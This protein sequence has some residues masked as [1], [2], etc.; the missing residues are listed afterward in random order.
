MKTNP[1]ISFIIPIYNFE[2]WISKCIDSILKQTNENYEIIIAD[3]GSTDNTG[4][5]C[6][7]YSNDYPNIKY[8]YLKHQGLPKTRVDSLDY[9]SGDYIAFVD[10]DDWVDKNFV[11]E[12]F[13]ITSRYDDV[14]IIYFYEEFVYSNKSIVRKHS[15]PPYSGLYNNKNGLI[16]IKKSILSSF[17]KKYPKLAIHYGHCLIK[18]DLVKKWIYYSPNLL[19]GEDRISLVEI[20]FNSSSI[21]FSDKILYYYNCNNPDSMTAQQGMGPDLDYYMKLYEKHNNKDTDLVYQLYFDY[22]DHLKICYFKVKLLQ[23]KGIL[24]IS[25]EFYKKEEESYKFFDRINNVS[26]CPF[27]F[28][29]LYW[30]IKIK[31]LPLYL[32]VYRILLKIKK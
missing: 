10:S 23:S 9:A 25:R 5:I 17:S 8:V 22:L 11:Q 12:C 29:A 19:I 14:N 20:I 3:D 15:V 18:K 2:S 6:K 32:L 1:L 7:K 31:C 27:Q 28:K 26:R 13:D 4:S 16:N 21:F 30:C 24:N